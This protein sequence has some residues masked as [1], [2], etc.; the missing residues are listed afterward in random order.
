MPTRSTAT[1]VPKWFATGV[2]GAIRIEVNGQLEYRA[3]SFTATL[4]PETL[5]LIEATATTASEGEALSLEPAAVMLTLLEGV[6][7][8]MPHIPVMVDGGTLVSHPG[9]EED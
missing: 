6:S 9:Y 8:S 4:N 7:A 3:P 1:A 5:E 2:P